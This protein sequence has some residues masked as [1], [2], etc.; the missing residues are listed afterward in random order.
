MEKYFWNGQ[1]G[2]AQFCFN[3]IVKSDD[4]KMILCC[5]DPVRKRFKYMN[6]EN[7]IKE[8]IDA[9]LFTE[10]ISLP[11]KKVC[12]EVFENIRKRI[13][14]ELE[15]KD[16]DAFEVDRLE[17]KMDKAMDNYIEIKNLDNNEKN[18]EYRAELSIL[19]NI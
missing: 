15:E 16:K 2:M 7:I 6:P 19:L 5:T 12:N 10:K 18:G 11:I 4:G 9:R 17:M 14:D 1:R 3:H 8:D 13:G